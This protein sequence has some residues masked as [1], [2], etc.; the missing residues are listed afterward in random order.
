MLVNSE[1]V[2]VMFFKI[3]ALKNFASFAEKKTP[4]LESLFNKVSYL[5]A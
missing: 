4:V 3:G 1:A 5:Q 2:F